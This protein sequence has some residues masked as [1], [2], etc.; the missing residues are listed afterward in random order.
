MR[1]QAWV[2][3]VWMV[4]LLAGV[5]ALA[6]E[7]V[8]LLDGRL[9]FNMPTGFRAWTDEEIFLKYPNARPPQ[10][11]YANEL[12]SVSIAVTY[13]ETAIAPAQLADLRS[14]MEQLLPR[15]IP[16]LEWIARETMDINGQPWVHFEFTSLAIDTE[17]HNDMYMTSLDGRMLAINMNSTEAEYAVVRGALARS[18][19]TLRVGGSAN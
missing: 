13:S 9:S 3:R 16:G 15:T 14:T 10:H 19:N 12:G 18:R 11:V 1:S 8:F 4:V 5:P 2:F 17:I 6:Q 7:A